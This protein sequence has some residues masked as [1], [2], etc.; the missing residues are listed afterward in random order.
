MPKIFL[1][2]LVCQKVLRYSG[3]SKVY[4]FSF[5]ILFSS[6]S[7]SGERYKKYP[8]PEQNQGWD[9]KYSTVPPWLLLAKPLIDALTGAPGGA[10]LPRSSEVVSL[11]GRVTKYLHQMYLSLRIFPG[12]HVFITAFYTR[13]CNIYYSKCQSRPGK[14]NWE[15]IRNCSCRCAPSTE[16]ETDSAV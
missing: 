11:P 5:S 12:R 13:K 14:E 15:K 4:R 6:F 10:F 7:D 2:L 8:P 16:S 9:T 3:F 1:L